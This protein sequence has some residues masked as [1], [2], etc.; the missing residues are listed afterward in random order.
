MAQRAGVEAIPTPIEVG[1]EMAALRRFFPE[2]VT[3]EGLGL[4]TRPAHVPGGFGG[5][6]PPSQSWLRTAEPVPRIRAASPATASG[7]TSHEKM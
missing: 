4:R 6:S 5:S 7:S 3:W 1:P 2:V